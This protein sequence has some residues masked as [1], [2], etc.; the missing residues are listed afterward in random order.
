MGL[1]VV[2]IVRKAVRTARMVP[3]NRD[4]PIKKKKEKMM[5]HSQ[6]YRI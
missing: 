6:Y 5:A 4:D 3:H 1:A 2:V